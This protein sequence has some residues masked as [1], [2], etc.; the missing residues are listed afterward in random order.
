MI[1]PL[2]DRHRRMIPMLALVLLALL[3]WA[4]MGPRS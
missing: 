3:A 1:R 4:L 2:R